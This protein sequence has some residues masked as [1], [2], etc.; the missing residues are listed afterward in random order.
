MSPAEIRARRKALEDQVTYARRSF[1]TAGGE[2][3]QATNALP[4]IKTDHSNALVDHFKGVPDI[5]IDALAQREDDAVKAI[6]TAKV[7]ENA[8]HR[9][10]EVSEAELRQFLYDNFDMLAKD[11]LK[12]SKRAEEAVRR[13]NAGIAEA[14]KFWREAFKAW[15][16]LCKAMS[17]EGRPDVKGV[18]DFP[19]TPAMT[20]ARPPSMTLREQEGEAA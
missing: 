13:I 16:P 11:A 5:D 2:H 4:Q 18:P 9:A 15:D 12:L 1:I 3:N 20:P 6:E 8:A 17:G 14:E 19:L 7:R 10:R